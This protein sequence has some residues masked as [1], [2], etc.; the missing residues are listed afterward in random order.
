MTSQYTAPALPVELTSRRN[1]LVWR[2]VEK[3][4]GKKPSKVPYYTNGAPRPGAQGTPEDRAQLVTFEAAVAC[5]ERSNGH[6]TGIGFAP[7]ADT[8]IVALDF[9][10]CVQD[11]VIAAHVEALCEGTYTE[12]SPSGT[13]VRAFFLG[14]LNSHKDTRAERGPFAIEVFG[15]S[16]FVTV[17]GN[18][19]PTCSMW[20]WDTVVAP[21]TQAVLS[22]Y[23]A[24]GWDLSAPA[25]DDGDADLRGLMALQPTLGWTVDQARGY[26]FDCDAATGRDNWLKALMAVHHELDASDA[27]FELVNEWSAQAP[28]YGGRDDVWGRWRSFGRNASATITG[29]WLLKWRAECLTKRKYLA[30][31][32]WK[33]KVAESTDEFALRERVCPTIAKDERLGDE[34]REK[35]A[36]VLFDR[37]KGLGA[38]FPIGQ[39]R[40]MIAPP[41]VAG[42]RDDDM[43]DWARG[44]VYVTD[45]DKFFRINSDEWLTQQAFNA[46]YDRFMPTNET[47]DPIRHASQGALNHWGLDHATR[48][49]YLPWAD[50]RFELEGVQFVNKYRQSSV[51]AAVDR[52]SPEG[53]KAVE[54]IVEH[55]KLL[56]GD[57]PALLATILAWLAHNVQKPGIKIRWAPLIKGIE[58]DGKSLLGSV[59]AA[60]MGRPN[61]RNVSPKVLGTDFTGWGEGAAV[62]VLEEIKLHGHNR[63]DIL[64]ALK[65]F[66]TNDSVPV[67]RK[68]MDEYDVVNTTNYIAFTNYADALPLNDTDRR[69]WIVF[70]P[71]ANR[72]ELIAAI[73]VRCGMADP[74]KYFD[75][76]HDAIHLHRAEL[77]RWLLDYAIPSSFKPN[78]SAPETEERQLMIA[79]S[80]TPEEEIVREIIAEKPLGVTE[81]VLT[82]ACLTEALVLKDTGVQ[83]ATT[84]VNRVLTKLGWTKVP[85][86]LKWRG[87]AHTVWVK[88]RVPNDPDSLRRAL[89][90]TLQI[91]AGSELAV[92]LFN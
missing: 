78:G 69:W 64:N 58:G 28:N 57:R 14:S 45:Q 85:Q 38:K 16:G 17:T 74:G 55:L 21:L 29:K 19:T 87:S 30:A 31:D 5:V 43:P 15:D 84:A 89:D 92:D 73:R 50:A 53:L 11:G 67:H 27:A 2:L 63:Y 86:R 36:Q 23:A 52:L 20:G 70:T 80:A 12:V 61:V 22:M 65:P 71:F 10:D 32:E 76:I 91:S 83:L 60:C 33:Q 90:A 39:C 56:T 82:S 1:W 68:G 46:K 25:L 6:Y 44:W 77:R 8:G 37:F 81:R 54:R 4:Q 41:R 24:R 13:G 75:A 48:A 40:K 42:R 9:D 72:E 34:E 26:L 7:Q 59:L 66:I 35:L 62:A 49:M 18:V 88:G 47:G 3:E 51:P 79:M